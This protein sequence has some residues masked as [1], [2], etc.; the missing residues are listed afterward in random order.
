MGQELKCEVRLGRERS[1][2]TALLETDELRF[3]GD[4]RLTIPFRSIT[5]IAA[6]DGGLTVKFDGRTATFELGARAAKWLEAIRNPKRVIDKL[7]VK[8]G[9]RVATRGLKDAGFLADL[10]QRAEIVA[11]A[12][13]DLDLV[14]YGVTKVAELSRLTTLRRSIAPAGGIW[15]LWP[16]G[17]AELKEDH[18]RAAALA[19]GLVDVKVVRFSETLSALKLVIPKHAR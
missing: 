10:E 5:S 18:V 17:R 7:G 19:I 4:F 11:G 12:G 15:V 2:G 9:M 13:R 1:A 8:P 16:K 14:F 3:R 6:K